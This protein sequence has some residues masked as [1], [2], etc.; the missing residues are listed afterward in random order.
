MFCILNYVLI[1]LL[2]L[3]HSN[4]IIDAAAETKLDAFKDRMKSSK[5]IMKVV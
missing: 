2:I 3:S 1:I 4:F 5:D